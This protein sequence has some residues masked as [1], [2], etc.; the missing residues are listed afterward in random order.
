MVGMIPWALGMFVVGVFIE[1]RIFGELI[2]IMALFIG[3]LVADLFKLHPN[4][5]SRLILR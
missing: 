1:I 3:N 2:A 4:G 5:S